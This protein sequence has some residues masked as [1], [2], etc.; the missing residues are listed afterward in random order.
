M[1][2]SSAQSGAIW[3]I[4][5]NTTDLSG[6][7]MRDPTN[8]T[9]SNTSVMIYQ[10]LW[11]PPGGW[12]QTGGTL[13]WRKVGTTTWN[14]VPLTWHANIN[15]NQYWKAS[16]PL[17]SI[18]AGQGVQ[19]YIR[20]NFDNTTS[21][22]FLYGWNQQTTNEA[23]A[24]ASPTTFYLIPHVTVNGV[25]ADYTTT[26]F[27]V[28]ES[29][30]E[31]FPVTV[32]VAMGNSPV[33]TV[34]VFT[35]LNNRNRA[36]LDANNDGIH[37][38]IFPPD[39][40]LI[41]TAH[42]NTYY[43][44]YTM[45]PGPG[46]NY[47][48]TL[49][50][51]KAGAYRLTVRW[52]L[53][54]DTNWTWWSKRDHAIVVSPKQAL[55]IRMYELNVLNQEASGTTYATRSTWEDLWDGPGAIHTNPNRTNQFNL[56]Y[57]INLG[58]NWIWFQ[59]VHPY[60]VDGRHLSAQ[61]IMNRDPGTQA[62]TWIWNNGSP[63]ENVHYPYALGS[64]YAVK[65]FWEIEPRMSAQHNSTDSITVQRQKAMQSFLAFAAAAKQ[66]GI[67]LMLDA[68]FNHTAHDV[69]L[70]D[71]GAQLFGGTPLQEIRNQEV[72]FF[73]RTGNY[74]RQAGIGPGE[75][76]A[77]APD[78]G[79]FGKWLDVKDV[80]FGV[81]AALVRVNPAEN[82]NYLSAGDWFN[83]SGDTG[84]DPGYFNS[85]TQKV[86]QY[87]GAYMP[88]WLNKTNNG[89]AGLRCDFGQGLPPQAWEY[90]INRARSHDPTV[91]FM[92]ETLDGGTGQG[93]PG[94]RS[95]R[96]FDILNENILFALK[97]TNYNNPTR[98][99]QS[100][101]T[102][103]VRNMMEE[104][105]NTYGY[106]LILLNTQSHDEDSYNSPWHALTNYAA[107]ATHEGAPMIFPGQELGI[108]KFYGYE[109]M[110]KN[111]GKFIPHFKTYNSMMPLWNDIDFGN[112]QLYPVY[113]AINRARAMSPALRAHNR[114]YINQTNGNPHPQI[115][116]VAKYEVPNGNPAI[117]DVVFAFVN[118][119]VNNSNN[120]NNNFPN[121]GTFNVN[122]T[123][124]GS[125]L[126]GINPT[127]SYNVINIAAYT[128]PNN[129]NPQRA[130]T[131]LW[132]SNRSGNSILNDGIYVAL[133]AVPTT[134]GGWSTAPYEPQY[135]KL[136]DMNAD[137]DG[138]GLT[139]E[140]ERQAGT[141]PLD[142]NSLLAIESIEPLANNHFK[143]TWKSVAGKTYQVQFTD[144]L[145]TPNWQN[146]G[147]PITAT[148][149]TTQFTDTTVPPTAVRRFYRVV[150]N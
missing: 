82:G 89:I 21:P 27:F 126:F 74:G 84:S 138:D 39:G 44:A 17:S 54:G 43:Q 122:V 62:S 116:S 81:Y 34:E 85:I 129:S 99:E 23:T 94:Y 28:D 115:F 14:A 67:K 10:G 124:N 48:L 6:T 50:A 70:G 117:Y 78:R 111:F 72:R 15:Q 26:K 3:H 9:L 19:Y 103:D 79:D 93:T 110:E 60:G 96:H 147:S 118:L 2:N 33:Q 90:I 25:N 32:Q 40:N 127:A 75:G 109:L 31:S 142:A 24:Q 139:N 8:P 42:T 136:M 58:V 47:S 128:G 107:A 98:P 114:Y 104:R 150:L 123:Q 20:T 130:Y 59:P 18:G 143:L 61:D 86:W 140:Q 80:F 71:L 88:Y 5:D 77:P 49:N 108:S 65:N 56:D 69:E 131:F 145:S 106:G 57:L 133:N 113:A 36:A 141:N 29:L 37:D 1:P 101:S 7:P 68:A 53:T 149:S 46:G 100:I 38:G 35:N 105:R 83:Y 11:K 112:D 45:N 73:S 64:P 137:N 16:I 97:N 120:V 41:T 63:F 134:P 119:G 125:N 51:S 76:P 52:K 144:N 66:K 132:P 22:R 148:G 91:V 102:T 13:Y 135:L 4:P 12:N 55:D 146:L 30:N 92:A 87:F 121:A 95:N